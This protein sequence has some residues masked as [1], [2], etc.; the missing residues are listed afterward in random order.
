MNI[1]KSYWNYIPIIICILL[2]YITGG[3]LSFGVKFLNALPFI[4]DETGRF[5][6]ILFGMGMLGA[7]TYC[8]RFWG[9]DIEETVYSREDLLPHF[10]DFIGYCG[11]IVGG[12]VSGVIIYLIV[13]TGIIVS[14]SS[15]NIPK[16]NFG[17]SI[18]IAYCGGLFHFRIQNVLSK[19]INKILQQKDDDKKEDHPPFSEE[20]KPRDPTDK[21]KIKNDKPTSLNVDE[22]ANKANAADVKNRAA[23]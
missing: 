13:K 21:S 1:H 6:L 22:S 20:C 7:S 17:V 3:Y 11:T 16:I 4:T 15:E 14:V 18:I 8:M 23:D 2:G 12:G 10:Y 19:F 9:L 5:T